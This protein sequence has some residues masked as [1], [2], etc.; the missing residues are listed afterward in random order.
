[1]IEEKKYCTRIPG[2]DPGSLSEEEIAAILDMNEVELFDK[3]CSI[4]ETLRADVKNDTSKLN[5]FE[6]LLG[7]DFCMYQTRRFGVDDFA[8]PEVGRQLLPSAKY[9]MWH[10]FY[11]SHFTQEVLNAYHQ[12]I[13][14]NQ[15]TTLYIPS[16]SWQ[17]T[18]NKKAKN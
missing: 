17:C 13:E 5:W 12:A 7:L 4:L 9:K 3:I 8:E 6:G 15:D 2:I 18:N 10:E 14:N 16:G 11:S 1:M